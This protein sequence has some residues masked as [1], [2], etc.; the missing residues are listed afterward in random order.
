M[1]VDD[2]IFYIWCMGI[3]VVVNQVELCWRTTFHFIS[4]I[5][6]KNYIIIYFLFFVCHLQFCNFV[7]GIYFSIRLF[8]ASTTVQQQY[9]NSTTTR[10]HYCLGGCDGDVYNISPDPSRWITV[11]PSSSIS[12]DAKPP[13]PKPE[14][15]I[16]W[17]KS[18]RYWKRMCQRSVKRRNNIV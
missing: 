7:W 5:Y 8:F 11:N 1:L 12:T 15:L 2:W 6:N 10:Q 14:I 9:N 16:H 3:Y 18:R 4:K 13:K 17:P